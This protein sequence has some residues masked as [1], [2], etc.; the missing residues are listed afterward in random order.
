MA[1]KQ[2]DQKTGKAD[3]VGSEAELIGRI[4]QSEQKLSEY[5]T[6]IITKSVTEQI[7]RRNMAR[8]RMFGII[9]VVVVSLMIPAITLWVRA[10][11]TSQTEVAIQ[12]QFSGAIEQLE[13][14]F[15][16]ETKRLEQEIESFQSKERIYLT[17]SNYALYLRDRRQVPERAL[18][19]VLEILEQIT[20]E[21]D[22]TSRP[23]FPFLVDLIVQTAI[24]HGYSDTLYILEKRLQNVLASAPRTMPR[25]A[26]HYGESIVGDRFISANRLEMV[27]KKFRR[28]LDLSIS[29]PDYGQLL[30]LQLLV[31]KE[32]DAEGAKERLE[33]IQLY[34][35]DLAPA[36]Q[37]AFIAET[38]RYSSPDYR[39][40]ST[41]ASNKRIAITAGTMVVDEA[42][43]YVDMLKDNAVHAALIQLANYEFNL[44]N[45]GIATA[46]ASF[47]QVVLS[48][49][50]TSFDLKLQKSVRR[51]VIGEINLWL[52]NPVII[53]ALRSQNH[54]T[55]GH[56]NL[57]IKELESNWQDEFV[58]NQY[59][60][61]AEVLDRPVS[62]YLK[63]VKLNG[64]GTYHEI[65]LMDGV[66]LLAGFSDPNDDYWQG[67]EPKWLKTYHGGKGALY[68]GNL[69]FDQSTLAWEI[70]VSLPVF[71]PE[72]QKPI[73]AVTIGVDPSALVESS[74]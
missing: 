60:L 18:K 64:L 44:E 41:T 39:D 34:V 12:G 6:T 35:L 67:E 36:Q 70:Q 33:A 40:V 53:E 31:E 72:T 32:L 42:Q 71:D 10:T 45:T 65:L 3:T 28:Y 47:P 7:E 68:I 73:G 13:M 29:T 23:D 14:R 49:I 51:L 1:E 15:V 56:S 48:G 22:L 19:T 50:S 5:F 2:D 11:I 61:I 74:R 24:K 20:P 38:I 43:F 63:R 25:L 17:F 66:G 59:D 26:R 4:I 16:D 30:S 9:S 58:S 57:I 55:S 8:L 37:A 62:R 46:L 69:K 27:I 21:P 54:T 52:T